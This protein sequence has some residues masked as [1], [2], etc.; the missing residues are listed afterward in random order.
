MG[1]TRTGRGTLSEVRDGSGDHWG[2]SGWVG[3]PSLRFGTG[4]GTLGESRTGRETLPEVRDRLGD[5]P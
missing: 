1:R 4:L 3:G 5:S 2:G